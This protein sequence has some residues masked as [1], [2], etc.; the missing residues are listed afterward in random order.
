MLKKVAVLTILMIALSIS[1]FAAARF[2]SISY[3]REEVKVKVS[4]DSQGAWVGCS[5]Y[6]PDGRIDAEAKQVVGDDIVTFGI[7][8]GASKCE[9]AL[10]RERWNNGEGP[11][12]ANA[13]G[14]INGYYLWNEIS[15]E[16]INFSN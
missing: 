11:D 8:E 5:F 6:T 2:V 12:P 10:W 16:S 7:P 13:W 4:V 14:E 1:V 9:V 3:N 15:R